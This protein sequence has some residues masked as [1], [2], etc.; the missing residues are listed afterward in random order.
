MPSEFVYAAG[1]ASG[2]WRF[3]GHFRWHEKNINVRITHSDLK[4]FCSG[5]AVIRL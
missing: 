5:Q 2:G 4:V 1:Q 3:A